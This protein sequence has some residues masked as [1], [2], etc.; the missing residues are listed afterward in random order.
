MTSPSMIQRPTI[1]IH[2]AGRAAASH[3]GHFVE[4]VLDDILALDEVDA[5]Q[6]FIG[7]MAVV[8]GLAE[9]DQ[10]GRGCQHLL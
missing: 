3:C 8:T 6:A 9:G 4:K 5:L 7:Q 1:I 10:Q 2:T